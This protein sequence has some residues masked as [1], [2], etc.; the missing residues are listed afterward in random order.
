[1]VMGKGEG[2]RQNQTEILLQLFFAKTYIRSREEWTNNYTDI[3]CDDYVFYSIYLNRSA[4][5]VFSSDFVKSNP[6]EWLLTV[7]LSEVWE[8][9]VVFYK[10]LS[11]ENIRSNIKI[12][13]D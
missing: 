9:P 5:G 10:L 8:I 11:W 6:L 1:M 3:H 2:A 13:T 7:F 12:L 4:I